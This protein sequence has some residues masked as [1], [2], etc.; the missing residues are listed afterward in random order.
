ME[1]LIISPTTNLLIP[2][3]PLSVN[4]AW[5]GRRFRSKEYDEYEADCFRLI[6]LIKGR[7]KVEGDVEI[8]YKFYLTQF[9]KMD[10]SNLIKLLEDILVKSELIEDDRKVIRFSAEKFRAKEDRVE[11]EIKSYG[12]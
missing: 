1:K 2:I 4:K 5:K 10:C 12:N 9:G 7:A 11:I 6:M 8:H 3:K